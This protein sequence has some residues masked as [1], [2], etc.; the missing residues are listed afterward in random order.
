MWI[1]FLLLLL[2][3]GFTLANERLYRTEQAIGKWFCTQLSGIYHHFV[4]VIVT[5]P[6]TGT[7][8]TTI[9]A[10]TLPG[11]TSTSAPIKKSR[12]VPMSE[13]SAQLKNILKEARDQPETFLAQIPP[14]FTKPTFHESTKRK[15]AAKQRWSCSSCGSLLSSDYMLQY[16]VV[17][18]KGI[19]STD[20]S[21][22]RAI[23][24]GANCKRLELQIPT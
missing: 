21:N 24:G 6:T 12:R 3:F 7:P 4:P 22:L 18:G 15:V 13:S 11:V 23:C 1:W 8:P 2:L 16:A 5:P 20:E 10:T 9:M 17:P 14:P 19:S